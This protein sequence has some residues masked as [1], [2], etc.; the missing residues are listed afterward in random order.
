MH[1][2]VAQHT[3][4]CITT[5]C[6]KLQFYLHDCRPR[7]HEHDCQNFGHSFKNSVHKCMFTIEVVW[8]LYSLTAVCR[9]TAVLLVPSRTKSLTCE[10][11][12]CCWHAIVV[13]LSCYCRINA[14]GM[15]AEV[16]WSCEYTR[17]VSIETFLPSRPLW[18]S[19]HILAKH[20]IT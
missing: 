18:P 11:D 1:K 17:L 15:R 19:K 16:L 3:C 7:L 10:L 12:Y 4:T 14:Y 5:N 6:I 2:L 9:A 8:F 20:P 13:L